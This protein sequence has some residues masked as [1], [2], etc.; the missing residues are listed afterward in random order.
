MSSSNNGK[1]PL[2]DNDSLTG[3]EKRRAKNRDARQIGPN[4]WN[5]FRKTNDDGPLLIGSPINEKQLAS[6]HIN[7]INSLQS[8]IRKASF[9]ITTLAFQSLPRGLRR[10]AASHNI[11]RLPLRLRVKATQEM[12]LSAPNPTKMRRRMRKPRPKSLVEEYLRRQGNKKWLETHMWHTKRMKMTDIWGYRLALYPNIK[13]ERTAYKASKHLSMLHDASYMGCIEMSGLM[14]DI[15]RVLNSITDSG[16]ASVGSAR[17]TKGQRIGHTNIYK[18]LGYPTKLV[19]PVTFLWRPTQAESDDATIWLWVHPSVFDEVYTSIRHVVQTYQSGLMQE[20]Q[21]VDQ[22]GDLVRFDLFG[23]RS[24]ALLQSILDPVCEASPLTEER[25]QKSAQ[26]WR[27]ISQLRSSSSLPPG[28]VLGMTVQDPRIKFPQK[29]PPRTSQIPKETDLRIDQIV[30]QWPTDVAYSDIWDKQLRRDIQKNKIKD[31]DLN[32]RRED[33]KSNGVKFEFT[34][35]DSKIP[36]LLIQRGGAEFSGGTSTGK[37][38]ANLIEVTEGWSIILPRSWGVAFWKSF[39]FA[40]ARTCGLHNVRAMHFESGHGVF[41]FDVPGT[42]AY[43]AQ[44]IASKNTERSIWAKKPPSKRVNFEKL[45]VSHPFEAPFEWLVN[46]GKTDN[47]K[48]KIL[49]VDKVKDE[50]TNENEH[51]IQKTQ[52]PKCWLLQGDRLISLLLSCRT[53]EEATQKLLKEMSTQMSKRDLPCPLSLDLDHALVKVRVKYTGRRKPHPNAMIFLIEDQKEYEKHAQKCKEPNS[54]NKSKVG[55]QDA[56]TNANEDADSD[57]EMDTSDHPNQHIG[58]LT[59]GGFSLSVGGGL[60]IGACTALGIQEIRNLDNRYNR[61]TK[62]LV[63]VRNTNTS[64]F[65]PAQ[66]QL[67]A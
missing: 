10:R 49:D 65:Q 14:S 7:E 13:S 53:Q 19:C 25:E 27:D 34:E 60:G 15:V 50:N 36:I 47:S 6:A 57:E 24:T 67:L 41:P 33:Q 5:G 54:T 12:A 45:G 31:N 21:V 52:D 51:Q 3:K 46:N 59:N 4:K 66:L 32:K 63:L 37:N 8:S 62:M 20:L 16:L 58:Y 42:L 64:N 1:R 39:V 40:G 55:H 11:N 22:R 35:K 29:V 28:C 26:L 38:S 23:P 2:E 48:N 61:K 9:A 56:N 44:S 43:E 17:Y 30:R 18:H